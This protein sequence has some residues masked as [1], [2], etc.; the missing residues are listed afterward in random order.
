[1]Q[2]DFTRLS[3]DELARDHHFRNWILHPDWESDLFWKEFLLNHPAQGDKVSLARELVIAA[4][5]ISGESLNSSRK[6]ILHGELI[7]KIERH[8]KHIRFRRIGFSLVAAVALLLISFAILDYATGTFDTTRVYTTKYG[9]RMEVVL[10]DG[11]LVDLNANSR[12][13]LGDR[14]DK[15]H[16]E[17]WLDGEAYF[18]VKKAYSTGVKFTVHTLDLDIEVLGTGFNVNSRSTETKVYLKEGKVRLVLKDH[19]EDRQ[20]LFLNPGDLAHFQEDKHQIT[21]QNSKQAESLVSWKS[22]YLIYNN[23]SLTQVIEDIQTSY[24]KEVMVID[25]TLLDRRINGALPT[26]DLSEF[27]KMTELLFN[28]K[29]NIEKNRIILK[30]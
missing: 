4:V 22:G 30:N 8:K 12:L 16:R 3:T 15:G 13:I 6:K 29:A 28:V 21:R 27:V 23:A 26:S 1:M 20:E 19:E 2:K 25:S 7:S 17:V 24:G 9:E 5:R 14:W 11:S 18:Q 10:P